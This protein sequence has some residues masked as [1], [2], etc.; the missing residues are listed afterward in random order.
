TTRKAWQERADLR[1]CRPTPR[2]GRHAQSRAHRERCTAQGRALPRNGIDRADP[3]GSREDQRR[4]RTLG[5]REGAATDARAPSA[6]RRRYRS[7][8]AL[9][10]SA[11]ERAARLRSN[12]DDHAAKTL[13][14][15]AHRSHDGRALPN[16]R[17]T[18]L[19]STGARRRLR[20]RR[21]LVKLLLGIPTSGAP[22][23]PFLESLAQLAIPGNVTSLEHYTV[24]GNF[25]PAQRELIVERALALGV[26]ALVMCDDD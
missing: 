10:R 24:Q 26:D 12:R 8:L 14:A 15:L 19:G 18:R 25:I 16:R 7:F 4:P 3:C 6:T 17:A 22:T 21:G 1:I 23:Q 20:C 13:R 11:R 9:E 5:F 2:L